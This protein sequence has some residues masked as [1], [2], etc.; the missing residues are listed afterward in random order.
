V[1][2]QIHSEM[3]EEA[4]RR[5]RRTSS[6]PFLSDPL[7]VE[8][9]CARPRPRIVATQQDRVFLGNGDLA[10]VCQCRSAPS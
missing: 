9:Q 8:A 1:L 3:N 4:S 6:G 2:P 5:S 10:Y 7:I